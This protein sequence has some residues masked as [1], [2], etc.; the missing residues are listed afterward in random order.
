MSLCTAEDS[1]AENRNPLDRGQVGRVLVLVQE[2]VLVSSPHLVLAVVLVLDLDLVLV[3]FLDLSP[4]GALGFGSDSR[5][6][7]APASDPSVNLVPGSL[8]SP[9]ST[10]W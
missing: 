6:C 2:F 10:W 8:P 7:L 5:P 1:P 9:S 3:G 4:A